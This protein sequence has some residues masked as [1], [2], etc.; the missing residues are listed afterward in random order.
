[1]SVVV[2]IRCHLI[3][4][5]QQ[6]Q[7][8]LLSTCMCMWTAGER[9]MHQK[10]PGSRRPSAAVSVDFAAWVH[11]RRKPASPEASRRR[12]ARTFHLIA[13]R[14]RSPIRLDTVVVSSSS[15]H[16]HVK[17]T[18]TCPALWCIRCQLVFASRWAQ[19]RHLLLSLMSC[20]VCCVSGSMQL[21]QA[22]A[23]PLHPPWWPSYICWTTFPVCTTDGASQE[24]QARRQL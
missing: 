3:L 5:W 1:L 22:V 23:M 11:C 6:L 13:C 9:S 2:V 12:T 4:P 15:E 10:E 16:L 20:L 14:E 24:V 19:H 21:P 17:R 18:Y 7:G 8:I